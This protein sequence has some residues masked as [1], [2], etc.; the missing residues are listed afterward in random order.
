MSVLLP[1]VD[2]VSLDGLKRMNVIMKV[3]NEQ[4]FS[5]LS[6]YT[7]DNSKISVVVKDGKIVGFKKINKNNDNNK[8][9]EIVKSNVVKESTGTIYHNIGGNKSVNLGMLDYRLNLINYKPK[10]EDK[11]IENVKQFELIVKVLSVVIKNIEK[12]TRDGIV[13]KTD[14]VMREFP[15]NHD[16]VKKVFDKI[17]SNGIIKWEWFKLIRN[18]K[19]RQWMKQLLIEGYR[20]NDA[21]MMIYSGKVSE[22]L[23]RGKEPGQNQQ[24]NDDLAVFTESGS[25]TPIDNV[26][27]KTSV[28]SINSQFSRVGSVNSRE[29]SY[30]RDEKSEKEE[31]IERNERSNKRKKVEIGEDEVVVKKVKSNTN[32]RDETVK[33]IKE[34]KKKYVI[35]FEMYDKLRKWESKGVKDEDRDVNYN[36]DKLIKMH[37]ELESIKSQVKSMRDKLL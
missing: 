33:L 21:Y 29:S 8:K 14:D 31:K 28:S 16:E 6:S 9:V 17:M 12:E 27:S 2:D 19:N 4:I 13:C 36:I 34:Y 1:N 18:F 35:Y 10:I 23:Q 25:T 15:G 32:E 26:S 37:N 11:D 20:P 30:E 22:E 3:N 7:C 5:L 24:I